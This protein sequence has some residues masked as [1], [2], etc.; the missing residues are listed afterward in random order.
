MQL[1][2]PRSAPINPHDLFLDAASC[3][4]FFNLRGSTEESLFQAAQH[5]VPESMSS[6]LGVL[7]TGMRS[8]HTTFIKDV[9]L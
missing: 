4:L 3:I 1:Q 9:T 7:S 5:L 2:S 8:L 6:R